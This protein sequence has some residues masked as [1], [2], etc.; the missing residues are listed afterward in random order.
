MERS[1]FPT[2]KNSIQRKCVECFL[3]CVWYAV[4]GN[5]SLAW[6]RSCTSSEKKS[7]P[8]KNGKYLKTIKAGLKVIWNNYLDFLKR[9][10]VETLRRIGS[11]NFQLICQLLECQI[12]TKIGRDLERGVC[13]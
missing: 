1:K 12:G 7:D 9:Q 8:H 6:S 5:V 10:M 11:I 2:L 3:S 13:I 4:K